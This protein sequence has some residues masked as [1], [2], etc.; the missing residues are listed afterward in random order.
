MSRENRGCS[1]NVE[2]C[3]GLEILLIHFFV[4]VFD[5][6]RFGIDIGIR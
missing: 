3:I 5:V 1:R 2:Y 4:Q 6:L